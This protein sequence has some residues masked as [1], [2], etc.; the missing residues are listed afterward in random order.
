MFKKIW[1]KEC[2]G[3]Y[4]MMCVMR[5]LD[6]FE[7]KE[8]TKLVTPFKCINRVLEEFSDVM[9][10]ELPK[11]LP[12]RRRVDHVIK[13]IPGVAPPAKAPYRMSHEKLKELKV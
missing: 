4:G 9:P 3:G 11:D 6:E 7:P 5:V 13:V 2:V 12:P 1:E 10:E 8:A